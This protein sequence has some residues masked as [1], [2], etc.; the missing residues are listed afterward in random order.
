MV[1]SASADGYGARMAL[2]TGSESLRFGMAGAFRSADVEAGAMDF[3]VE[4]LS[5]DLYAGWRSSGGL[6]VNG[7]VGLADDN[8][9]DI[10]RQTTLAAVQAEGK[11]EGMTTGAKVQAGT[12]FDMGGLRLSPRAAVS[13]VSTEIDGYNEDSVA[14]SYE[15]AGRTV[16]SVSGEVA[17]RLEGDLSDSFGFYAE[18]GY[19]DELDDST[20][21]VSVGLRNN[22]AQD[23]L[24]DVETPF[25]QSLL[26]NAGIEG[27]MGPIGVSVGYRGRFADALDS[28]MATIGL[29]VSF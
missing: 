13:W 9:S 26:L 7:V 18:G 1:A 19:R 4:S 17:L 24:T 23:I 8:Y 16:E 29:K 6:F 3:T 14:A 21:A 12:W 5:L 20:E 22:S 15:Y 25:G 2:E 27:K 28:H 10:T 11:T